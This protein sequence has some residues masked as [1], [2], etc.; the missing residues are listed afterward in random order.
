[1]IPAFGEQKT[2][3]YIKD[4]TLFSLV[5]KEA[6]KPAILHTIADIGRK[7]SDKKDFLSFVMKNDLQN[8]PEFLPMLTGNSDF[9]RLVLSKYPVAKKGSTP[10]ILLD[11][12]YHRAIDIHNASELD[13][14][15][16]AGYFN[17]VLLRLYE[18]GTDGLSEASRSLVYDQLKNAVLKDDQ[19]CL[20][21][22]VFLLLVLPLLL[23]AGLSDRYIG[24]LT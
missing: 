1:M 13:H 3:Q 10:S 6:E 9:F 20:K 14:A 8:E 15:V 24:F 12:A 18:T 16:S 11:S 17:L 23:L 22:L 7:L 19:N 5:L 4:R 2:M 21:V